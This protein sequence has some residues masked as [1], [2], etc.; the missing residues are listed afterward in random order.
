VTMDQDASS[1]AILEPANNI[2]YGRDD[3]PCGRDGQIKDLVLDLTANI[4]FEQVMLR[5]PHDADYRGPPLCR[6]E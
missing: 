3:I 5:L 1:F 2:G 6:A 4:S